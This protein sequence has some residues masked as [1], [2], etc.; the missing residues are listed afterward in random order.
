MTTEELEYIV[1]RNLEKSCQESGISLEYQELKF[2][3]ANKNY[4]RITDAIEAT[5][6]VDDNNIFKPMSLKEILSI[7]YM[8]INY[9]LGSSFTQEEW[10]NMLDIVERSDS[11]AVM[12]GYFSNAT[13]IIT[14]KQINMISIP[15]LDCSGSVVCLNHETAHYLEDYKSANRIH[16]NYH[17]QEVLSQ[18]FEKITAYLLQEWDI[19]DKVVEGINA[20]RIDAVRFHVNSV[21]ESEVLFNQCKQLP[22]MT[23][24]V[25]K[26]GQAVY[27]YTKHKAYNYALGLTYATRLFNLYLTD[28]KTFLEQLQKLYKGEAKL[29]DLLS[30]YNVSLR[31]RETVED[32]L[33]LIKKY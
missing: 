25:L 23:P 21:A 3:K 26:E 24:D 5:T 20:I 8:A 18:L 10:L 32:T 6:V 19:D 33:E 17:Y 12:D 9:M 31:N 29:D 2:S 1:A 11:E 28:Q 16:N 4:N 14:K 27:E 7:S 13:N 15:R 30:Y 22:G